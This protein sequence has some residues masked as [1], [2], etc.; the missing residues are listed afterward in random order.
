M[1]SVTVSIALQNFLSCLN[2]VGTWKNATVALYKEN[3]AWDHSALH[4]S[5]LVFMANG[6]FTIRNI[7]LQ[8]TIFSKR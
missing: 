4:G 8:F 2:P 1:N 5:D 6:Q 7:S 3:Q